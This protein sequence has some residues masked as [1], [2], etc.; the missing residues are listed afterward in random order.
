MVGFD[1]LIYV[2]DAGSEEVVVLD[3]AGRELGRKYV[4]GAKAVAQ[5]RT[6]DL[7]VIGEFDTTL[8]DGGTPRQYTFSA[9]Y[10]LDQFGGNG[11][12]LSQIC[13]FK[14]NAS[15]SKGSNVSTEGGC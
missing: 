14:E 13:L 8:I 5:D 15:R 12:N 4:Q 6:F 1:E 3:Q 2:V 11:Y 9:I 10:R 7:L